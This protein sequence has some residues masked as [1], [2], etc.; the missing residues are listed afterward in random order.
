MSNEM[1]KTIS[2]RELFTG[3][4]KPSPSE[5]HRVEHQNTCKD[6]INILRTLSSIK[7]VT[8]EQF[9]KR[10]TGVVVVSLKREVLAR[11]HVIKL[12]RK[13]S[14]RTKL[15]TTNEK[16]LELL[17]LVYKKTGMPIYTFPLHKAIYGCGPTNFD[18]G[19]FA[20][21]II[22]YMAIIATTI[23]M[24]SFDSGE[25][26]T[27]Y[28]QRTSTRRCFIGLSLFALSM[29]LFALPEKMFKVVDSTQGLRKR[30]DVPQTDK[31]CSHQI[32]L[33]ILHVKGTKPDIEYYREILDVK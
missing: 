3:A 8:V 28:E 16:G 7:G 15:L 29:S 9:D 18:C 5:S 13:L 1:P 27:G 12:L 23:Y 33:V 25:E 26:P 19:K 2:R 11:I 4:K 22:V 14:D 31:L 20:R 6:P 24:A 10:D 30:F 32:P 21:F 17:K